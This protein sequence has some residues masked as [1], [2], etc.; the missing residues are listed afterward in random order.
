MPK[1]TF[2]SLLI[3]NKKITLSG[4]IIISLLLA[5][6]LVM[7]VG[8][9]RSPKKI[10]QI[11]KTQPKSSFQPGNENNLFGILTQEQINVLPEKKR[12][13]VTYSI[14]HMTAQDREKMTV[15]FR[16]KKIKSSLLAMSSLLYF[17]PYG[18]FDEE[19]DGSSTYYSSN[20]NFSWKVK[21]GWTFFPIYANSIRFEAPGSN[22]D[23][24]LAFD[25]S[26]FKEC[27]STMTYEDHIKKGVDRRILESSMDI[28]YTMIQKKGP[29]KVKIQNWDAIRYTYYQNGGGMNNK[30]TN[31][32]FHI[33][34]HYLNI[35]GQF[36]DITYKY[37]DEASYNKYIKDVEWM[38]QSFKPDLKSCDEN[39]EGF[40]DIQINSLYP[41][42][43]YSMYE[44]NK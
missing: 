29:E 32:K 38:I 9:T 23:R 11:T 14:G 16:S 5:F 15:F 44:R 18:F 1:H 2:A 17:Y 24:N 42:N 20:H 12:E 43:G 28:E 19:K 33:V 35:D 21:L 26:I 4:M 41:P 3:K 40:S 37:L 10:I 7:I 27:N 34:D 31:G 13:I 22:Y 6:G 8:S 25:Y 39:K 30:A 36:Y